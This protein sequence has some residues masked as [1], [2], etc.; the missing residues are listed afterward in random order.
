[1]QYKGTTPLGRNRADHNWLNS[2][3]QVPCKWQLSELQRPQ[4]VQGI[5]V[6]DQLK[7]ELLQQTGLVLS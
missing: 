7:Q 3:T 2:A 1:M 4:L 6:F 5:V